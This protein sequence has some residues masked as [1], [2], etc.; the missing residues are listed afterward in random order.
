MGRLK[1][2][3]ALLLVCT[4]FAGC[5][6]GC[7]KGE[8]K[9]KDKTTQETNNPGEENSG[10]K[11]DSSGDKT[12]FSGGETDGSG[13]KTDSSGGKTDS[14]GGKTD[15]SGDGSGAGTVLPLGMDYI[16]GSNLAAGVDFGEITVVYGTE[17]AKPQY[18]ADM[19]AELPQE[20]FVASAGSVGGDGAGSGASG[21]GSGSGAGGGTG[22]SGEAVEAEF[23]IN[24]LY[25][26]MNYWWGVIFEEMEGMTDAE[27]AE[28]LI[29]Y[30]AAMLTCQTEG[31]VTAEA[32]EKGLAVV[33]M[34]PHPVLLN[35]YGT[36]LMYA[37]EYDLALDVFEIVHDQTGDLAIVLTNIA[38]C[39]YE[40]GDIV[41]AKKCCEEA[42]V[43]KQ[44]FGPALQLL[45]S[46]SLE[47]G[48]PLK[49]L[50]YMF[51]SAETY[52]NPVSADHFTK[53]MI[54]LEEE[55]ARTGIHPFEEY[56]HLYDL[57]VTA[58]K[59]GSDKTFTGKTKAMS[60]VAV[61]NLEAAEDYL[62][63]SADAAHDKYYDT[64]I[65]TIPDKWGDKILPYQATMVSG[66]L[67]N[68][69]F[70]LQGW[71]KDMDLSAASQLYCF[72]ILMDY[73]EYQF[74][75]RENKTHTITD[76]AGNYLNPYT[77]VFS[78]WDQ[79]DGIEEAWKKASEV[80]GEEYYADYLELG[81][82]WE[83]IWEAHK[84]SQRHADGSK[85]N[86]YNKCND[87]YRLEAQQNVDFC[88]L[89]YEHELDQRDM[90]LQ[91]LGRMYAADDAYWSG[92][93][94]P[95]AEAFYKE[96]TMLLQYIP[97]ETIQGYCSDVVEAEMY[98]YGTTVPYMWAADR[99]DG[100]ELARYM[101]DHYIEELGIADQ[102]LEKE[103]HV[104]KLEIDA[105]GLKPYQDT[106][107]WGKKAEYDLVLTDLLYEKTQD[108]QEIIGLKGPFTGVE[109]KFNLTK[110]EGSIV[111]GYNGNAMVPM[112]DI[113]DGLAGVYGE[114]Y[115]N[116]PYLPKKFADSIG[117]TPDNVEKAEKT[118]EE[119]IKGPVNWGAKQIVNKQKEKISG[120]IPTTREQS[121]KVYSEIT[122][123][124]G[125]VLQR[126]IIDRTS[127]KGEVELGEGEGAHKIGAGYTKTITR[128]GCAVKTQRQIDMSFLGM[129]L[130][131]TK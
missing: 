70:E 123:S 52:W 35:N 118:V 111:G 17:N 130:Q 94:K 54:F 93:I 103:R 69:M 79:I 40:K 15:N 66:E 59:A 11:T 115:R 122:D 57:V 26:S 46:I 91:Y 6:S 44:G 98:Y 92:H 87:C 107:V 20:F 68:A 23:F 71:D 67:T 3:L 39:Y 7:G 27:K 14:S 55:Q 112:T 65:D 89:G 10:G 31:K 42:L 108:G 62:V 43:E 88:E 5:L 32:L 9:E 113:K 74:R 80:R 47:E 53:A 128:M 48:E 76:K 99:A 60:Y 83:E 131:Y 63:E 100:L 19:E 124:Q 58:L 56:P 129:K 21:D 95:Y 73:Y 109:Y 16:L 86:P 77:P 37:E 81:M 25:T 105:M 85:D 114:F 127:L 22:G 36:M 49:A 12:D 4:L 119:F 90:R 38:S 13:G 82:E 101:L 97:D 2:C 64:V 72:E 61:G 96:M 30:S 41:N 45:C 78:L 126:K 84:K 1:R 125:R 8:D 24:D 102:R 50:E 51:R 116:M 110:F 75:K 28:H 34:Y 33:S 117:L 104:L 121:S 29:S 106:D 120:F 18:F